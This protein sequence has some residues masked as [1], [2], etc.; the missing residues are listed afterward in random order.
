MASEQSLEREDGTVR[1]DRAQR[2]LY[3]KWSLIRALELGTRERQPT[4]FVLLKKAGAVPSNVRA[5]VKKNITKP[6]A[7]QRPYNVRTWRKLAHLR[8]HH[9]R[10]LL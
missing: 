9:V 8:N 10:I 4:T 2:S 7:F 5:M 1:S 3:Q 6:V